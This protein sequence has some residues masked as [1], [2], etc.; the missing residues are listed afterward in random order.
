VLSFAIGSIELGIGLGK[1]PTAEEVL[2]AT[3]P[4]RYGPELDMILDN[5]DLNARQVLHAWKTRALGGKDGQL[6][7][8]FTV[9]DY[10]A[11]ALFLIPLLLYLVVF[12]WGFTSARLNP[13]AAVQ[14]LGAI[15]FIGSCMGFVL[16]Q[17]F[18][19][20]LIAKKALQAI[21]A[22]AQSESAHRR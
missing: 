4:K 11:C 1:K 12:G 18:L 10:S 7:R 16:R 20:Q 17:Y 5:T 15:L 21:A 9:L 2:K 8:Q 22:F 19:P 3:A 14:C 6:V 13:L